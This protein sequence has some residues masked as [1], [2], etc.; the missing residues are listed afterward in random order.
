MQLKENLAKRKKRY[1]TTFDFTNKFTY[2]TK[3]CKECNHTGYLGRIAAY[4]V[5]EMTDEIKDLIVSGASSLK[6][7]ELALAQGYRP[8]VIDAFNKVVDGI[9]T[10]EEL[11]KRLALY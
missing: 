9:T 3:G 7:R 6:I 8:L 2:D 11:N 10:I 5:L 1:K 4:E